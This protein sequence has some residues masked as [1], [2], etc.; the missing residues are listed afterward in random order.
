MAEYDGSD[1]TRR[2]VKSG[3]RVIVSL[4]IPDTGFDLSYM[5]PE[6]GLLT[7]NKPTLMVGDYT[8]FIDIK[9][10]DVEG[11]KVVGGYLGNFT[12]RMLNEINGM[13][14]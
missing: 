3:E 2:G 9:L 1:Y 4:Y 6:E 10:I 13:I 7:L 5:Y 12:V 11:E 14:K 8:Y